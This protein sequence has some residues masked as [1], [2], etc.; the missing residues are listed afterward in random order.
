MLRSAHEL[1]NYVL[2]ALD[3]DIGR[4]KDFL[5]DE[6]HWAIRY[7]VADTGKWLPGRKVLI[8]PVSLESP[9]WA[10]QRF[11]V[12]L[13]KAQVSN[14]PSIHEDEPVSLQY[15]KEFFDTYEYHYY[16][17][18][19]SAWGPEHSAL[20]LQ[21]HPHT[22]TGKQVGVHM[23][24]L[25]ST[26]EVK[27]CDIQAIDGG[28]GHVEDFIVEEDTWVIRYLVLST[29]KFFPGGKKVLLSPQWAREIHWEAKS[30]SVDMS[31][32]DILKSP[33]Y[34]PREAVNRKYEKILYNYY[35]QPVYW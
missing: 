3:G 15:E 24:H 21:N 6:T 33:E 32:N 26:E 8:T 22:K 23:N 27:G 20:A 17:S 19:P 18:G 13:T 7:M 11:P 25:R 1:K 9:D 5:F 14:A 28:I 35:G 10:S 16:W 30:L 29:R 12:K 31:R 4:C 2:H 34:N